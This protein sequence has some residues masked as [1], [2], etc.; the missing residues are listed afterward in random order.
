M[1]DLRKPNLDRARKKAS[2]R[3]KS[4]FN[5]YKKTRNR[6][7]QILRNNGVFLPWDR[8]K[9]ILANLRSGYVTFDYVRDQTD[10]WKKNQVD[11]ALDANRGSQYDWD[12]W[13]IRK[14]YDKVLQ[15]VQTIARVKNVPLSA[16][17]AAAT[18]QRI[19]TGQKTFASFRSEV[20]KV[21][22]ELD[23]DGAVDDIADESPSEDV[24]EF[25]FKTSVRG[26]FPFL[27]D[28]LINAFVKGWEETG[29]PENGLQSMRDDPAY[30]MY[31]PG[32]RLAPGTFAMTEADYVSYRAQARDIMREY[33][34]PP[35]Y[36][37]RDEDFGSLVKNQV[38][39]SQLEERIRKGYVAAMQAP[40]E[41]RE[42]LARDFGVGVGSLAA[43]WLDPKRG[44][45]LLQ[46]KF[47]EAQIRGA[48]RTSGWGELDL[49]QSDLLA[50][51]GVDERSA[52]EGFTALVETGGLFEGMVGSREEDIALEDQ[53]GATFLGDAEQRERIRRRAESRLAAFGGG[54]GAASGQSGVTGLRTAE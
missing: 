42:E 19:T 41:V 48:A 21:A 11:R 17:D 43:F 46:R 14:G 49:E 24:E 37:D 26:M 18:A 2:K 3:D 53:L 20:G 40:T 31:F 27:Q 35:E 38:K 4:Y 15:R 25:D 33:D 9:V 34:I 50:S 47:V 30:D 5:N 6:L 29:D 52:R 32:N 54:G 23:T 16:S 1:A 13:A 8:K 12:L 45:D 39:L 44:E 7:E 22:G 51:Y 28:P 36:F 10:R